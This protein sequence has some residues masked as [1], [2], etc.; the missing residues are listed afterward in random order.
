MKN[1]YFPR[2]KCEQKKTK[3][4]KNYKN[5]ITDLKKNR[6]LSVVSSLEKI[7]KKIVFLVQYDQY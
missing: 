6:K 7:T 3:Q 1:R 4:S 2:K 5:I